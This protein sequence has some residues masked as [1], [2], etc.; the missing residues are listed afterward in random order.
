MPATGVL[1]IQGDFDKHVEALLGAGADPN[2]V[3]LV[4]TPEQLAEVD[5]LIIPGGE[6]TTV[7]LLLERYGLGDAIKAR[8]R[9]GMPVWGTCMGMILMATDVEGPPQYTLGLLDITVRRN[10]FG[11]QVHSFEDEVAVSELGGPVTGVFIRA[12]IV[13]R[14]GTGVSPFGTYEGATVGARQGR[15]LGTA[16]HPELTEDVRLHR[17]FLRL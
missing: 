11:A 9:E 14:L 1:A 8:A 13:T 16:F 7:G 3:K 12:P 5:R 15:L 10:A 2:A 17:F 4:R 6:S